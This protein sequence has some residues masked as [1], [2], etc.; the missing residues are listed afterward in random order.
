MKF[1]RMAIEKESPEE[2]GYGNIECNLSESSVSDAV[3]GDLEIRLQDLGLAYVEHR[4][5]LQLREVIASQYT[6]VGADD[7]LVTP[8]AAAALFML[9]VVLLDKGD[10]VVVEHPNY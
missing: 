9:H 5:D 2:F 8:G 3:L 10:H 6:G 4:G 7:V 1:R